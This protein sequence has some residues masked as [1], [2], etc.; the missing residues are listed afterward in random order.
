M[1]AACLDHT[2]QPLNSPCTARAEAALKRD[3][4]HA[5]SPQRSRETG[6]CRVLSLSDS[7][8]QIPVERAFCGR[9][10]SRV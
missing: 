5:K 3:I 4:A 6:I 9:D 10:I 2:N 1:Y 8:L 7:T